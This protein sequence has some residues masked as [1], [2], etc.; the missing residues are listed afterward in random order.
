[1]T[2]QTPVFLFL[3]PVLLPALV[4]LYFRQQPAAFNFPS[5]SFFKDL[6]VTWRVRLRHVPFFLRMV[7]V[8]LFLVALA[9]PQSVTE[10]ARSKAEGINMALL[11]DT[12]TSMAAED[13]T[14]NGKRQNRLNVI[15]SVLKD[16]IAQRSSDRLALI[17]FAAK[18]YTVSPLTSDQVWLLQNLDRVRFG[19]MEDGTAIG[20]AIASGI[21]RLR[22]IEG[23]SKVM[24]LLTDGVN[25]AGKIA[26]LEAAEAAA[27]MGIKIYTIG[28]GTKDFVPYPVQDFFGRR[29]Y[30]QVKIEI[31]E[32]I[33]RKIAE[34]T[35]GEY[36]RATDTASLKDIY[37]RIDK[38]E[39]VKFDETGYRQVE[40]YFDVALLVALMLLL[41]EVILART[42]FL[43][44][45]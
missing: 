17:A 41:I 36:F 4:Y 13:F 1:M 39:K 8:A 3:I 22:K 40:E 15:K 18:P 19:L 10:D 35:G 7:V 27:V 29:V 23:K 38:M 11:L 31:D 32:D 2:F 45:P 34:K 24:I 25:N 12:S 43:R 6:N 14:I 9:G 28:A 33:L 16:F 26:P 5:V 20:S 21:S 44:I 42:V 30:Q 37:S